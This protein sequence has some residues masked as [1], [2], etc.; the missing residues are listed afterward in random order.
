MLY[1]V[2]LREPYLLSVRSYVLLVSGLMFPY[3]TTMLRHHYNVASS[4]LPPRHLMVTDSAFG[5]II[6]WLRQLSLGFAEAKLASPPASPPAT[7]D[8]QG[9]SG[10]DA[11]RAPQLPPSLPG[12][13]RDLWAP[14]GALWAPTGGPEGSVH[15][16][17]HQTWVLGAYGQASEGVSEGPPKHQN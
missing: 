3:V 12:P 1:I 5:R 14:V 13:Q 11:R 15:G 16:V 2:T 10:E 17:A 6:S 9:R 4:L 8:P 7:C